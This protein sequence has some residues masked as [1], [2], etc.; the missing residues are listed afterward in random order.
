MTT[1]IPTIALG[2]LAL[3]AGGLLAAGSLGTNDPAPPAPRKPLVEA[4]SNQP[5]S[6]KPTGPWKEAKVLEQA[7]WLA[8]SVAYSGD[9][10]SLFVGGTDGQLRAYES[11]TWKQMWEYKAGG[12]FAAVAVAPETQGAEKG[13]PVAVTFQDGLRTGFHLL[14]GASGKLNT[15]LDDRGGPAP[16]PRTVPRR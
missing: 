9:G 14:D 12:K 4:R 15:T 3:I 11:A 5:D 6:P 7:G 2:T 8:G 1:S 16:H 10:K 13:F